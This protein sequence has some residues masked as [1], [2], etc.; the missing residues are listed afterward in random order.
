M[1]WRRKWPPTP[2]LLP[3][4]SHG[5]KSLVG[6]SCKQLDMTEHTHILDTWKSTLSSINLMTS[7]FLIS[8][9]INIAFHSFNFNLF[10]SLYVKWI[11]YGLKI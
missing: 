9:S 8:V 1:L 5:Q 10:V 6:Y 2:V 3:G 4:Q 11:S 7:A